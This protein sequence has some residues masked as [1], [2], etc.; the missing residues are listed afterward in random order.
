MIVG[1][2]Y[3]LERID[4]VARNRNLQVPGLVFTEA[5]CAH[6]ARQRDPAKALAGHFVAKEAFFKA[7][8]GHA[9]FYWTDVEVVHT[10][11]RLAQFRLAN[12][13]GRLVT[14][15]NWDVKLTISYTNLYAAACVVVAERP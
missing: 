7:L 1:T 15:N 4:A 14:Q 3:D 12:D 2:G 9:P 13:I 5:E 6:A 10:D 8:A 11:R